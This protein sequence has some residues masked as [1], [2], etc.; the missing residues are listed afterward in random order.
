MDE[1][2]VL[3]WSNPTT[4]LSVDSDTTRRQKAG[5]N[6][7]KIECLDGSCVCCMSDLVELLRGSEIAR[8]MIRLEFLDSMK[9]VCHS[10]FPP[11]FRLMGKKHL[12][13]P[14]L[15]D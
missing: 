10:P 15:N 1:I 14:K 8:V 4:H 6:G 3:R 7:I 12:Q 13:R 2:G 9:R 5:S 11:L